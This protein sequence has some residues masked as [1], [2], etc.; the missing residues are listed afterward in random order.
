MANIYPNSRRFVGNLPHEWIT[1]IPKAKRKETIQ[2]IQD[3]R[4]M[5]NLL[6]IF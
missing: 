1:K 6:L 2:E 5:N 3:F 4:K